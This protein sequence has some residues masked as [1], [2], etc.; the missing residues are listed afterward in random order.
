MKTQLHVFLFTV[1]FI[2]SLSVLKAQY[3]STIYGEIEDFENGNVILFEA[4]TRDTLAQSKIINHRFTLQSKKGEVSGQAIPAMMMCLRE[5]GKHSLAAPIAI[6]NAYLNVKLNGT[7]AHTYSGTASQAAFSKF[8]ADIKQADAKI[9]AAQTESL[10][11]SL[12]R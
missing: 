12:K 5:D 1:L 11:D 9:T 3:A 6:E 4:L 8:Y 2:P 10:Q 7:L